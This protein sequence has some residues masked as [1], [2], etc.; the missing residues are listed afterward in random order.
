M[1][2]RMSDPILRR[3]PALVASCALILLFTVAVTWLWAHAGHAPLPTRGAQVDVE[4]GQ[5][6]ISR[7]AR[8]ALDVQTAEVGLRPLEERILAYATLVAPWQRHAYV[9]TRLAGR[10]DKLYVKP[11]QTVASGQVLAEVKSLE[12]ENLKLDLVNV[13]NDVELSAKILASLESTTG[14]ISEQRIWEARSKHLENLN[15]LEIAKSKWLSFGLPHE[16]LD[17]LLR[18]R[19]PQVLGSLPVRSPIGG[20]VIHADVTVGKVVEPTEHLFEIVDLSTVWVKIGVLEKDLYQVAVGQPIEL[21]LAAYPN[22]EFRTRV[23]VK[24]LYLDP[25]T[26]LGTVWAELSNS[27]KQEPRLLPGMN[28]QAQIVIPGSQKMTAVPAEALL[29]EGAERYVLVEEAAAANA[30]EYRKK[31][32]VVRLQTPGYALVEG[33]VFPGDR[34]VTRGGHELASFFVQGVLRL[35]DEAKQSIRLRVEPIQRQPVDEVVEADGIVDVPP[36]RRTFASSQLAGSL[37]RILVDRGQVVRAGDVL[38]EVTSLELLD[39]QMD[40]LRAHLQT[41]LLQESLQR[42]RG[43]EGVLPR[44]QLWETEGAFNAARNRRDSLQRKLGAAGLSHAQ[45]EGVLKEKKL[46]EAL[47]LRAPID[48]T[49]VHFDKVLGQVIKAEQ[50]LFEIHDLSHVWMQ[51][52]LSEQD[53]ARVRINPQSPLPVRLRL[54]ADPSYVGLGTVQRSGRVL[55]ADNHALSI[56]VELGGPPPATVQHNMLARLS[57]PVGQSTPVL[58]LPL[59]AVVH[60]GTRGYVFVQKPDGSFERRAVTTGRADDRLIEIESGLQPGEPVVVQGATELQT[61]Y[62]VVR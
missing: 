52:F 3:R 24:G 7:D 44:R 12:L 21:R 53:L 5:M 46:V 40:L 36:D 15:A 62:A 47:P 43:I 61:A 42:L 31:N 17:R 29:G 11:G 49:V 25:Q 16:D 26:H 14:A 57:I 32:V 18:Q 13:Q 4:K 19:D 30:S 10:I 41:Q 9:T 33:G 20:I 38:A 50:P 28:G 37:R 59:A 51:G 2:F 60:E 22:E 27:G 1:F 56:W 8:T 55:D 54:V 34:V 45:I 6:V 35:S 58:A 48:G 23:Q 39:L